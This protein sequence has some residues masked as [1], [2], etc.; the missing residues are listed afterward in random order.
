MSM[1][2]LEVIHVV[3]TPPETFETSLLEKVSAIIKKNLYE[4]RLLLI[5]RIRRIIAHY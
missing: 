3:I 5:G 2:E 4:T 1:V